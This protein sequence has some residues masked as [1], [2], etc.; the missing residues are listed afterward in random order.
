MSPSPSDSTAFTIAAYMRVTSLAVSAYD[1]LET[2]P[3]AWRFY[4]EHWQSRRLTISVVLFALLRFVSIATLIVS[5]IGF[6]YPF[7]TDKTCK[8]FYLVPPSFKVAQAMVTQAILGVRAFNLS[9]R[10]KGVGYCLLVMYFV[11]CVLQWTFTLVHRTRNMSSKSL[12]EN[13]LTR[14]SCRAVNKVKALG[15]YLFYAIAIVYDIC[16]TSISIY[17]LL[18]YKLTSTNSV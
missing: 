14:N 13:N 17:Y 1:Y 5:N 11:A 18:K 9:R 6:F 10:S 16:T 2:Q 12:P 3:T 15:A 8:H 4:K 7:F